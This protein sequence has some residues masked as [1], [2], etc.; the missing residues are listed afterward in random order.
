[1]VSRVQ[2]S[3]DREI[4]AKIGKQDDKLKE[5]EAD[6]RGVKTHLMKVSESLNEL[7]QQIDKPNNVKHH[8]ETS[9]Q[10]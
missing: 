5:F 1:M 2:D 6:L 8:N 9:L 4:S 3:R 7:N 10:R